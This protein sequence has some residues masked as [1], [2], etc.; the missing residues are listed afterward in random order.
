MD[1]GCGGSGAISMPAADPLASEY[2]AHYI[3]TPTT[4]NQAE[5]DGLI[6]A[7]RLAST[8]GFDSLRVCGDSHLLLQ[9]MR[10]LNRIRHPGL[11]K[12]YMQARELSS[13][14]HCEFH[15]RTRDKNQ[16]ADFLSKLA[17]DS[18]CDFGTRPDV[19]P[20]ALTHIPTLH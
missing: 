15:H 2:L 16:V 11:R 12:Q 9:Q 1:V 4:N 17:P 6:E 5:Y 13:Q 7:L 10:G 19:K 3:P 8:Q 14:F 20:L 18:A